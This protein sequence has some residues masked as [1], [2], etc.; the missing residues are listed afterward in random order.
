MT[1]NQPEKFYQNWLKT[2]G[3][4]EMS[5]NDG[6]SSPNTACF[7]TQQ[8][9][10]KLL[11]GLLAFVQDEFPKTHDLVVLATRLK[12]YGIDAGGIASEIE[13]LNRFYT[14]ARYPDDLEILSQQEA[15]KAFESAKRIKAFVMSKIQS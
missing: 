4:D 9:A 10:E 6:I 14:Q 5:L 1:D 11:K 7:L 15:D 13:Y 8:M 2:A 3:F 12:K